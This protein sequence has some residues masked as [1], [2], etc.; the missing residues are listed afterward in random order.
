MTTVSWEHFWLNE[1]WTRFI[2]GKI[3][4][5]M[6][7]DESIRKFD[8]SLEL[9]HLADDIN[10][11][12]E[13]NKYE[14]TALLPDFTSS[15]PEDAFSAVPYEKGQNLLCYVEEK[16]GG[17]TAFAPYIKEY[18]KT[19]KD[20]PVNTKMWLDYLR[21]YFP[22]K[23]E[24]LES[25]PWKEI[26][27]K[28]G[29]MVFKRD[30]TNPLTEKCKEICSK[31]LL[32]PEHVHFQQ[33]VAELEDCSKLSTD[34]KTEI[35]RSICETNPKWT[36]EKFW[37]FTNHLY[38]SETKNCEIRTPWLRIGLSCELEEVIDPAVELVETVG[39]LKFCQPLYRALYAWEVSRPKAIETFQRMKEFMNPIT[40]RNVAIDLGL[41]DE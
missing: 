1:G 9:K 26:F 38:V 19:F 2:D 29:P 25:L 36:R 16:V 32:A 28:P 17:P 11:F 15:N 34:A 8:A 13:Q 37:A 12:K 5:I 27:F 22:D 21:T 14:L 20:T 18:L 3:K 30:L 24:V 35:L 6:A 31:W 41:K 39:R 23:S 10:T 7:G 33:I 4:A 40:K